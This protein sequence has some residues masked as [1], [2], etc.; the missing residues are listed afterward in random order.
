[1]TTDP[2]IIMG[3]KTAVVGAEASQVDGDVAVIDLLDILP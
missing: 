3:R 2:K 1:M